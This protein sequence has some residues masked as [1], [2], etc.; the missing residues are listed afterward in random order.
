MTNEGAAL[1]KE[2]SSESLTYADI[3]S[4]FPSAKPSLAM[5]LSWCRR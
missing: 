5:L 2:F 4:K 1:L 3:L